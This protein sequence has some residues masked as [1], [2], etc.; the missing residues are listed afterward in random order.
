MPL[1]IE[2]NR[3]DKRNLVF[4]TPA[5][6]AAHPFAAQIGIVHPHLAA[7]GVLGIALGHRLHD[8]MLNQP[9]GGVAHAERA[10]QG[11]RR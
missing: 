3:R 8:L 4:G 5:G 7:P 2:G 10:L 11:Q 9:G 6:F 1:G